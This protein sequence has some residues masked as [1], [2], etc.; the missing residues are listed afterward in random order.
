VKA[1]NRSLDVFQ[2]VNGQWQIIRSINY[3]EKR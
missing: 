2:D 3:P 1:R